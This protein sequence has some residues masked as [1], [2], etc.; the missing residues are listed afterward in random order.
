MASKMIKIGRW[1]IPDELFERYLRL[2]SATERS[3]ERYNYDFD[4]QREVVH[5]EI[6]DYLGLMVHMND[7]R[8]FQRA[9]T[10]LCEEMLPARFTP[11]QITKLKPPI[12]R[13]TNDV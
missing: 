2:I 7:Y 1:E 8:E 13:M 10:D 11:Q 5:Q 4:T 12:R 9:L 6:L 3:S